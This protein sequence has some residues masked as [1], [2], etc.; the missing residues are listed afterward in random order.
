MSSQ[1][2]LKEQ[3]LNPGRIS[4]IGRE[5]KAACP[6]FCATAFTALSPGS[7]HLAL[8]VNGRRHPPR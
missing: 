1:V 4:S 3:A 5:M 8:Q 7:Y 6:G 2:P